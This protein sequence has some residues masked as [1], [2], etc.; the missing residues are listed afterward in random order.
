MQ[1]SIKIE[2]HGICPVCG[3]ET[4]PII[5][6]ESY[7]NATACAHCG[8]VVNREGKIELASKTKKESK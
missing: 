7:A 3:N 6:L 1:D 8:S 2:N 4:L 5:R